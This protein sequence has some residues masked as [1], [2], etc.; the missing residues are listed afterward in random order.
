[1]K[2]RNLLMAAMSLCLVAIIAVGGTLAY[3][4][5]KAGTVVNTFT[6]GK[7]DIDLYESV[8]TKYNPETN[9]SEIIT[10]RD[11]TPFV[12]PEDYWYHDGS[13]F[14]DTK[15]GLTYSS[16]LPG[17]KLDKL[18]YV[19]LSEDSV[20]SYIAVRLWVEPVNEKA[21]TEEVKQ[22]LDD[23]L[24][25]SLTRLGK[26][27][28]V[29]AL[30]DATSAADIVLP[31]REVKADGNGFKYSSKDPEWVA[32]RLED[33]SILLVATPWDNNLGIDLPLG[34]TRAGDSLNI[35]N[36]LFIGEPDSHNN[37][38]MGSTYGNELAGVQ[39]KI[40]S[41]AFAMQYDNLVGGKSLEA[42]T[43][44][45]SIAAAQASWKVFAE[46]VLEAC[47]EGKVDDVFE[48]AN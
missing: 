28:D 24:V 33:D 14:P 9:A 26:C 46:T 22:I 17:D 30:G 20:N 38:P 29:P 42:G 43:D 25:T 1:M 4:T 18:M 48:T 21:Q 44:E 31:L 37:Y 3:F 19:D 41:E 8:P 34:V 36:N 23:I 11:G 15:V 6:T 10:N 7:V 32:Y 16:V 27:S 39:F 45:D 40:N 5:D 2:K 47:N 13:K 12:D 35:L